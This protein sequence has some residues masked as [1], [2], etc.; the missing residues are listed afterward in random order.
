MVSTDR[1]LCLYDAAPLS[2]DQASGQARSN[3]HLSRAGLIERCNLYLSSH[4]AGTR[5][6]A[7][8]FERRPQLNK[9]SLLKGKRVRRIFQRLAPRE[10]LRP[11]TAYRSALLVQARQA[12]PH[13][14]RSFLSK[15]SCPPCRPGSFGA[16]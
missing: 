13:P 5:M 15:D 12:S 9:H 6:D 8:C 1:F 3:Q 2:A 16:I 11:D 4:K 14:H 7:W 10:S